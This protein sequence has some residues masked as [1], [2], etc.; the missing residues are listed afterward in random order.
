MRLSRAFIPTLKEIPADAQVLSHIYMVRGGFIRQLAA[1]IY[2]FLPLGWRVVF[3]IENIVREEMDRAGA[4]EVLMPAATPAEL[5]QE[6]GR[7]EKYGPELLRFKDRKGGDFCFGPTHEEVI[8]DMVRRDT[9]SYRDL[10]LNLYQIQGKFRDELRPRAGLMRGREFIM[11]DAYSFDVSVEAASQAY[12]AMYA[13]YE[14]IFRRCGLD[15]RVVEADT[16]A[17]G[18]LR[19]HEFQVLAETGE[20]AIVSCDACDYAANVEQ[21]EILAPEQPG[22]APEPG[23]DGGDGTELCAVDTPGAKTIEQ[24]TAFLKIAPQK[25]IKTL[26]YL[27]DDKVVLALVR[28]DRAVNEVALKK[29]TGATRLFLAR[30]GQVKDVL[31]AAPG[32]VGPVGLSG[33]DIAGVYADLELAGAAGAVCGGN[34]A[35]VH[36][37]GVDLARDAQVTE[38]LALRMAEAGDTCPR[39]RKGTLRSYRG[40]EVGHVFYLSTAYTAPLKCTFLDEKGDEKLMEMGCYG[41]GIT[42]IAAAAI[43]QNHDG[44]GII[45][46]MSIAPYEVQVIPLQMNDAE[47]VAEGERIYE[48]LGQRGVDVLIDD[49]DERPGAKFKD[50]DLIGVPLRVAIGK[51]SLNDGK[52]EVKWRKGGDAELV[53]V[54]AVI[55]HVV[56]LV[57]AERARLRAVSSGT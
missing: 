5:W 42:R 6:S 28:G 39:C 3:K 44:N 24:V 55:D 52:V 22:I 54:D 41:I 2:N 33:K 16:G 26:V 7:W 51:R 57:E 45:W 46:P 47:V 53:A 10:P 31:G 43:E 11:K 20:D 18:G 29:R 9:K 49:R 8:V 40:I 48:A 34:Q 56:S 19:S 14:R 4:Q 1:G 30:E 50:A 15:F 25:L 37:V 12:D 17:I 13:A 36:H 27:A 35:D 38:F 23:P 21:A 32:F